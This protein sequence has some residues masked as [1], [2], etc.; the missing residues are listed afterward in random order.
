MHTNIF[1]VFSSLILL[2]CDN[3]DV[4]II[5]HKYDVNNNCIEGIPIKI[6]VIENG[7]NEPQNA[8]IYCTIDRE[9]LYISLDGTNNWP[10]DL[11]AKFS[12]CNEIE[13]EA[14]RFLCDNAP[15]K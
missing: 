4:D 13:R 5:A 11:K 15:V 1:I 2:S 7:S 12:A 10:D 9:R 3:E 14:A 6:G 8:E